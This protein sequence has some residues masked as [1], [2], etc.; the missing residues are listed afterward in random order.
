M[1]RTLAFSTVAASALAASTAAFAEPV[2][3]GVLECAGGPSVGYVIGSNAALNCV[4]RPSTRRGGEGYVGSMNR[5]GLDVG[6]TTGTGLGW[7]VFAPSR[8]VS[9]GALAGSY[10]GV[11][12]NAAVGVGGGANVLVGGL[13]NSITLQPVSVQGQTGL[14]LAATVTNVEL[15]PVRATVVRT[16]KRS[17]K[18]KS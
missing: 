13:N 9:R 1:F 17:K 16:V 14:N 7:L 4:F 6:V 15:R 12:A 10:G 8:N 5:V 3:I 2:Q 11:S 18:K